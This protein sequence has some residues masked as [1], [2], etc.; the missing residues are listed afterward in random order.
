MQILGY[1]CGAVALVC[2]I[3]VLIKTFSDKEKN[4]VV[5]GII[6]IVTC[7]LWSLIWGWINAGRL[8]ITKVMIIWT[9]A[10]VLSWIFNGMAMAS[11]LNSQ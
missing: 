7:S 8:N 4:G 9:V 11:M 1:A 5:H 2:W 3:L 6:G 10:I